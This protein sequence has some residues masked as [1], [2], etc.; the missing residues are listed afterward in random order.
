MCRHGAMRHFATSVTYVCN[1][2]MNFRRYYIPDSAV[3][4]TQVVQDR[5]PVFRDAGNLNLLRKI[6]RNVSELHAF[7]MLGYVFLLDHFHMI[8]QPTGKSNFSDIM[9]SSQTSQDNTRYLLG[10]NQLNP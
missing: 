2:G 1:L 5:E 6:L 7:V 8:I 3:F 9:H 10:S 4:I